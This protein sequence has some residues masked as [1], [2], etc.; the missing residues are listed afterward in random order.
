MDLSRYLASHRRMPGSK[1]RDSLAQEF[2]NDRSRILYSAPFRRLG[3]KTQVFPVQSNAS[4][5][6]RITHTLEV[7][8][9]GRLIAQEVSEKLIKDQKL[10]PDCQLAF[11]L[12]VENACLLHD[13]GNPPFGHFG[14]QAI[15]SWFCENWK[16]CFKQATGLLSEA[17]IPETNPITRHIED[18]LQF[19]GNPQGIRIALRLQRDLHEHGMNLT[20]STILAA[21]KYT[22]SSAQTG[23]T[24]TCKKPGYFETE[25]PIIEELKVDMGIDL[26]S[27]HPAT[28][29]MEAADDIAYCISDIEDGIE[30][31]ILS[32]DDFFKL[33]TEEWK[34]IEPDKKVP[35]LDE[36][37]NGDS[38]KSFFLFK[39][40]FTSGMIEE[41]AKTFLQ[42]M[43]EATL[44]LPELFPQDSTPNKLFRCLK[45]VARRKLFRSSEAENPELAG[46]NIIKGL[47]NGFRPLLTCSKTDFNALICA[48]KDPKNVGDYLQLHWRLFDKLPKKY[49]RSYQDQVAA[50]QIDGFHEWHLR[51][52][53]I[54]DNIASMTDGYALE[55]FQILSGNRISS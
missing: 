43:N 42:H 25:R 48:D 49:I 3:Q 24:G 38:W 29:I 23:G 28:Y 21:T 45:T 54:V 11:V 14:E 4:V 16:S 32:P 22:R 20:C 37:D 15:S 36:T 40:R 50:L 18:F 44:N 1:S 26:N 27:R 31:E 9:V 52:H 17:V 6:N 46:Y 41:A 7:S 30:K 5:R 47:L 2:A 51:A 8:D 39:T 10:A 12:L 34:R 33:F 13:L 53:L 55:T 19:D 35:Y